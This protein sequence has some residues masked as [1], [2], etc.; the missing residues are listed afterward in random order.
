VIVTQV[1][2]VVRGKT[3]VLDTCLVRYQLENRDSVPHKVGLRFMLDTYIGAEDG[4]PFAI[5]GKKGLCDTMEDFDTAVKVG[6]PAAQAA[7]KNNTS[8]VA[9]ECPLAA[10]H[11]MQVMEMEAGQTKPKPFRADHPIEIFARAYMPK[12]TLDD[13]PQD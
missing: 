12:E 5:P 11:L 8:H 7:L 6:K 1:V 13:A 9:S 4:V 10:E 3:N 2:E